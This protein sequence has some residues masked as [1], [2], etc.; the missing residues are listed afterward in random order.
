MKRAILLLAVA[1]ALGPLAGCAQNQASGRSQFTAFV[2]AEEETRIGREEHPKVL[3]QFGGE[4]NNPRVKAYVQRIGARLAQRSELAGQPFTFTVLNSDVS[5]AFAL[6][7]GY[8]YISR[9]LMGLMGSEAELAS[10]LGHEIGHVTARHTAE[11]ISRGQAA[12][13]FTQILGVGVAVLTGSGDVG[14]LAAQATGA[15]AGVWL[16]GFSREQE[17][18]ADKLG[19]RY[20]ASDGYDPREAAD[21][22]AKLGEET[23]F[24]A[25]LLG[26]SPESAEEFSLMQSHP[27]TADRVVAA[28]EAAKAQGLVVAPNARVGVAEYYDAI[29]GMAFMG[30]RESG[31]VRGT[32]FVHP[33]LRIRFD[34]PKGFRISNATDA[35]TARGPNGASLK[36][37]AVRTQAARSPREFLVGVWARGA[38]LQNVET[39]QINGLP[40]AT[41]PARVRG[42]NG[43]TDVRLVA[44]QHPDG[45][46]YRLVLAAPTQAAAQFDEEF[47]RTTYSFRV[48]SEAEAQAAQPLRIRTVPVRAGDTQEAFARRMATADG[49]ELERFQLLNALKPG[50][51]LAPGS[52]VKIVSDR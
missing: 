33:A 38:N 10:V 28:L 18:E 39:I 20:M 24:T 14:N 49:F 16:A 27:R 4:Y 23:R 19:V 2:S 34:A 36:L 40:A 25:K 13:I 44:I 8:I 21:M 9:G 47:R 50:D 5:N 48:L 46:F 51:A 22:L 3:E 17:F 11:R 30:D 7:G 15:G 43:T 37:D 26:R 6:P 45:A 52:R 42:Q 31:F 1:L 41:A 12:N 29:D 35:V 32:S